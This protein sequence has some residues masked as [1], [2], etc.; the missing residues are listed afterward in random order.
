MA[1][2]DARDGA[3]VRETAPAKLNLYLHLLGRRADGYHLIDSLVVF[4]VVGDAVEV[5]PGDG[6][7]L[8][9]T[10]PFASALAE[11]H[12]NLV[13]RAARRLAAVGG[14]SADA[15]IRLHKA[16]P[17]AAGLGGGSADAA[18]ALRALAA[19]WRLRPDENELLRLGLE[20]GA[21]VPACLAGRAAFVGGIGEAIEPA[22]SLPPVFTVLVNPRTP[23]A[24]KDVYA[25]FAGTFSQPARF[26]G[27][28]R[29]AQE[30]AAWLTERAN[31]LEAPALRL[32]PAVGEVLAALA[33]E[34]GCLLARMSG[35]GAT[36]FGLFA[37]AEAASAA[38]ARIAAARPGWWVVSTALADHSTRRNSGAETR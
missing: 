13:V 28:P 19:F 25:A 34:P 1:R 9:V 23:L 6:L 30:L 32:A 15:A 4:A 17:V 36:C 18:A 12:D 10:G 35:S 2:V 24:T 8:D 3:G 21:D 31:D 20:L 29:D 26:A 38:A 7:S 37:T 27:A 16:L 22:P 11:T 5:A 33:A 14:V